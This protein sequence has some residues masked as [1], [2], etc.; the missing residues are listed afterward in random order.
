LFVQRNISGTALLAARLQARADVRE[1]AR[2]ALG[3]TTER[4]IARAQ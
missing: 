1:L 4:A 3:G 2:Q